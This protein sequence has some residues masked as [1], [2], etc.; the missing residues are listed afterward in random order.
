MQARTLWPFP[1]NLTRSW[2]PYRRTLAQL[3]QAVRWR[4]DQ[5]NITGNYDD[6]WLDDPELNH[7][8][9]LAIGWVY[10]L[11]VQSGL[12]YDESVQTIT[13]AGSA[14]SYDVPEDYYVTLGLDYQSGGCFYE[15]PQL[16][17]HER[18]WFQN[19]SGQFPCGFR[20]VSSGIKLQ[21]TPADG[22]V[23]RHTY[24]PAPP[25][26]SNDSDDFDFGNTWNDLVE[27]NACIRVREKDEASTTSLEREQER[28]LRRI[29]SEVEHRALTQPMRIKDVE[30]LRFT[31]R[32]PWPWDDWWDC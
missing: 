26:L 7:Y 24:V 13:T 10:G 12:S 29:E 22:V 11:K 32:S 2:M 16:Y 21:P 28:L 18:N 19:H 15:V 6:A 1:I 25:V 3:R 5:E 9:N 31:A 27:V 14:S 23:L 20:V 30:D 17:F 4:M 8:I